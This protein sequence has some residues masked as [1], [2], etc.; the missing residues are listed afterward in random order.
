MAINQ[1]VIYAAHFYLG[2][3]QLLRSH[4]GWECPIKS[5]QKWTWGGVNDHV[6]AFAF[7]KSSFINY[8]GHLEI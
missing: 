6:S 2:V 1:V 3:I 8:K 4:L 5:E 7:Y